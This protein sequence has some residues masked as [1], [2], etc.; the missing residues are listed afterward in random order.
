MVESQ[1]AQLSDDQARELIEQVDM[2]L[3]EVDNLDGGGGATAAAAVEALIDLYGAVLGRVMLQVTHAP[4]AELLPSL[5]HDELVGHVLMAH[6]LLPAPPELTTEP[7]PPPAPAPV[8]EV[9]VNFAGRKPSPV[10]G[11][12]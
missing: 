10:G 8:T 5:T 6:G 9:P 1:M 11:A 4:P 12:M 3:G 7:P 2:L